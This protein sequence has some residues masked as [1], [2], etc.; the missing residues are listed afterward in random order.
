MEGRGRGQRGKSRGQYSQERSMRIAPLGPRTLGV[1]AL[2]LVGCLSLSLAAG[3]QDAPPRGGPGRSPD[4][5]AKAALSAAARA[6]AE[7]P[8]YRW[9][10]TV[11][12]GDMGPFGGGGGVTTGETEK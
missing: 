6:L 1:V 2:S 8:G 12:A 11:K 3:M 4:N 10:T 5:D 9:T 7:A